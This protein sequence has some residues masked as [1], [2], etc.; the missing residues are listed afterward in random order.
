MR[1]PEQIELIVTGPGLGTGAATGERRGESH[2]IV[3]G[4]IVMRQRH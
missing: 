2:E 4:W 3:T 1:E